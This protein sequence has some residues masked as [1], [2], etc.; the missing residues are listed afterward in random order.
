MYLAEVALETFPVQERGLTMLVDMRDT[1]VMSL[2]SITLRDMRR[3]K[4]MWH[5]GFPAKLKVSQRTHGWTNQLRS[6]PEGGAYQRLNAC[7]PAAQSILILGVSG[8]AKGVLG[9]MLQLL[10][11]KLRDRVMLLGGV[12]DLQKHVAAQELP[13]ELGGMLEWDWADVAEGLLRREDTGGRE[14]SGVQGC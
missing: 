4:K 6:G 8:L 7:S 11:K 2:R 9:L 12:E 1:S 5:D 3:G 10:G 13:E 14:A